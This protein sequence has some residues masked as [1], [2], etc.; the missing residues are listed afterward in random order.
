MLT[1]NIF[2]LFSVLAAGTVAAQAKWIKFNNNE[3]TTA[4]VEPTS[5]RRE[6]NVATVW[7]LFDRKSV[8]TDGTASAKV[9]YAINCTNQMSATAAIVNMSKLQGQ[10]KVLASAAFK[11]SELQWRPSAPGSIASGLADV[12]CESQK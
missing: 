12:I 10:G 9:Q 5:I 1:K 6:G 3:E 2:I 11:P 4:F 8:G 7:V